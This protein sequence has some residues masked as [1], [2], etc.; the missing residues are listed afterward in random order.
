[1]TSS[2]SAAGGSSLAAE[3]LWLSGLLAQGGLAKE[4]APYTFPLDDSGSGNGGAGDSGQFELSRDDTLEFIGLLNSQDLHVAQREFCVL[5]SRLERRSMEGLTQRLLLVLRRQKRELAALDYDARKTGRVHLGKRQVAASQ[6]GTTVLVQR[7]PDATV[8]SSVPHARMGSLRASSGSARG[9]GEQREQ[10]RQQQARARVASPVGSLSGQPMPQVFRRLTAPADG[11]EGDPASVHT[12]LDQSDLTS[13]SDILGAV[14]AAHEDETGYAA[15]Q[16]GRELS[17]DVDMYGQ[18]IAR[19]SEEKAKEIFDRL[20]KSGKDHRVRRRVY[21]ELGILVDQA[22]HDQTC[23]FVPNVPLAAQSGCGSVTERLYRDGRDRDRRREEMSRNAPVPTF[24][25]RISP[26]SAGLATS[27]SALS[28]G[29]MN[30]QSDSEYQPDLREDLLED[31]GSTSYESRHVRLFREHEERRNRKMQREDRNA[32]WK[33]H[34]FRPNIASS[35]ATGPQVFRQSSA[36][37]IR[38]D[39]LACY[40]QEVVEQR[41]PMHPEMAPPP[42]GPP[43][44]AVPS[45]A[46]AA[47]AA[48]AAASPQSDSS[49]M[50]SSPHRDGSTIDEE[51][52]EDMDVQD[53]VECDAEFEGNLSPEDSMVV[54]SAGPSVTAVLVEDDIITGATP[55]EAYGVADMES[56]PDSP[57]SWQN[58][59][60]AHGASVGSVDQ[61]GVMDAMGDQYSVGSG[62]SPHA[63]GDQYSTSSGL[64]PRYTDVGGHGAV[65]GLLT[66]AQPAPSMQ[67]VAVV[68]GPDGLAYTPYVKAPP[69][70]PGPASELQAGSVGAVSRD[71]SVATY[72]SSVCLTPLMPTS[73]RSPPT[74]VFSGRSSPPADSGPPLVVMVSPPTFAHRGVEAFD[75]MT[76]PASGSRST[77]GAGF[78]RHQ[79]MMAA[80]TQLAAA[81]A[82]TAPATTALGGNGQMI[83]PHPSTWPVALQHVPTTAAMP[84]HIGQGPAIAGPAPHTYMLPAR[85]AP[86]GLHKSMSASIPMFRH[87]AASPFVGGARPMVVLTT[88]RHPAVMNPNAAGMN[89][90]MPHYVGPGPAAG[91]ATHLAAGTPVTPMM[92]VGR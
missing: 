36:T 86:Q 20:Y 57:H 7:R 39:D 60:V 73:P 31:Q 40:V 14:I 2:G 24:H 6:G 34:S 12:L 32:E 53:H 35:Q 88:P 45:L 17:H 41:P 48:T 5:L 18:R 92:G 15:S 21:H 37:G 87:G 61:G 42:P 58:D 43:I 30:H 72:H 77:V 55:H 79:P 26:S 29:G 89:G 67:T 33:K 71:V 22:K 59:S 62:H 23:T 91:N 76:T 70:L 44:L 69:V 54:P 1:M 47:A 81:P 13:A 25:P 66:S 78:V 65:P 9:L 56:Q 52:L 28:L 27:Q 49:Q 85:G 19:V 38:C 51:S 74:R 10:F 80:S 68:V 75:P 50:P 46:A 4:G 16:L 83:P 8:G 11:V 3:V 63:M 64:S 82:G 84:P 90:V